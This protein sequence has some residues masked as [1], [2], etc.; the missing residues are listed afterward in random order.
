MRSAPS[1]VLTLAVAA[2]LLSCGGDHT[3][4][5]PSADKQATRVTSKAHPKDSTAA[6]TVSNGATPFGSITKRGPRTST[7]C[8]RRQRELLAVR[9]L[10]VRRPGS[11][12]LKGAETSISA[13]VADVC[14]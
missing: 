7:V 8:A 1:F 5:G 4:T 14:N 11:A 3:P 6:I 10:L 13:A 2:T 9:A 12:K